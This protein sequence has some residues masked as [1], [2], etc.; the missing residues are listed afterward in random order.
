MARYA[1]DGKTLRE[2]K[3]RGE[4]ALSVVTLAGQRLRRVLA[5]RGV[6]GPMSWLPNSCAGRGNSAMNSVVV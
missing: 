4:A 3:R 1:I 5:E 6:E 2:S